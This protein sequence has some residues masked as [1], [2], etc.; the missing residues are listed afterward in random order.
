M[1]RFPL[2][3]VASALALAA[4]APRAASALPALHVHGQRFEDDRGAVV[5]LR[6]ANVTGDAK[7]PPF[8]PVTDPKFFDPLPALGMNVIRLLF[9]W[10]AYEPSPGQYD[11]KYLD[12]YAAAAHAAAAHGIYVIVDFHQDAFSRFSLGGCGEGFPKWALPPDVPPDAPDNGPSCADWSMRLTGDTKMQKAW[13]DFFAD[14]HGARTR[15]VAMVGTVAQRMA[16]EDGVLGYDMLN[17]PWANEVKELSPFYEDVAASLR[18]AHPGAVL[19][20]SPQVLT[21]AGTPPTALP[22]PTFDNF[23]YSPHFYDPSL[24]IFKSWGGTGVEEA[25]QSMNATAAGWGVPLF[26]GEFGAPSGAVHGGLYIDAIMSHLDQ[27]FASC[28]QWAYTPGW[29]PDKKDG[30]NTEDFSIVDDHGKWRDNY[31]PRPFARRIAGTPTSIAVTRATPAGEASAV[32][33]WSHD[34]AMGAT[35]IFVPSQAFFGVDTP[36][37]ETEG[38]VLTC[39]F[40]ASVI[41]CLSPVAGTKRVTV[42]KTAPAKVDASKCGLT[43]IE[44]VL[45]VP[46]LGAL[47]RRALSTRDRGC[48]RSASR[49]TRP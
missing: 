49:P 34:P 13:A 33:E 15:Y 44:L 2:L 48:R 43:G 7:V 22:K 4:L 11:A 42:V 12:Y 30:W 3:P 29:T 28:T 23:A 31:G 19:F 18:K 41:T 37:I 9:T 21:S 17:E 8:T 10:E 47:R 1:P 16:K 39:A 24:L 26:L 45:L 36:G 27:G 25:F 35:E 20:V 40:Q 46:L 38:D 5:V 6:G 32:V 14:G